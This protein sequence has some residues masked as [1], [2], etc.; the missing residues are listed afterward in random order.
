MSGVHGFNSGTVSR[1][2][3]EI[4]E[5]EEA[6]DDVFGEDSRDGA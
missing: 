1:E 6:R 3:L 4:G 5:G 2:M